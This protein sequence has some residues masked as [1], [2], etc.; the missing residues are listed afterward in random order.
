MIK[1]FSTKCK[2]STQ[3]NYYDVT[4]RVCNHAPGTYCG[5]FREFQKKEQNDNL[6]IAELT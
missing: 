3:C 6:N 5:R 2:Y 4:S 1:T